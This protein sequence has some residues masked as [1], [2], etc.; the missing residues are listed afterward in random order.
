MGYEHL[1]SEIWIDTKEENLV[2]IYFAP[3]QKKLTNKYD[4][5]TFDS[6]EPIAN[7]LIKFTKSCL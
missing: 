3:E 2:P 7:L 1:K 6:F 5:L 4:E